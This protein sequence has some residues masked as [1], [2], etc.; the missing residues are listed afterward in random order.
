MYFSN[1]SLMDFKWL[2]HYRYGVNPYSI[3]Q[4][5]EQENIFR[6]IYTKAYVLGWF[7][8]FVMFLSMVHATISWFIFTKVDIISG[9]RICNCLTMVNM[10]TSP[11]CCS[12]CKALYTAHIIPHPEAPSLKQYMLHCLLRVYKRTRWVRVYIKTNRFYW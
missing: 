8:H 7:P 2:N 10:S 12:C 1:F 4:F 6:Y 9:R 5:N 11:S 3:D